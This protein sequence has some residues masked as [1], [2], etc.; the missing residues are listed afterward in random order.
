MKFE[1]Y[2]KEFNKNDNEYIKTDISNT[3]CTDWLKEEIPV[4]ECSDKVIEK[5]YY[6][7]WWTYRKHIKNT[8]EGYVITEFLPKVSWSGIYNVINAPV[9]H[10]LMEGRWLKNAEKYIT[11]YINIFFNYPEVGLRYSNWLIWAIN[12]FGEVKN[13]IDKK[14][15]LKKSVPY[16]KMWEETHKTE[17]EL[18][19]SVDGRDA[20]EFSISGSPHKKAIPGLRPTLNSYMYGEAK[21]IYL[22]SKECGTPKE[23]Y[24]EKSEKIKNA[25]QMLLWRE[26]F[27]K[28]VHPENGKFNEISS[29]DTANVPRELIGYI[30]WYFSIPDSGD[31]LFELLE[32]KDVFLAEQGLTTAEKSAKDFLYEADHECL[33][34]GYVWPFAT[35]QTLTALI[36]TMMKSE[37]NRTK[38]SDMFYRLLSL[39][40][41]QH[42][43]INEYGKEVMWIDEVMSPFKHIWTSREKLKQWGWK[44]EK[45]GFE[46]GKDYNHSTFCDLVISALTGFN[47]KNG[48]VKFDPII[49]STWEYFSIDNLYIRGSRY[50]I[51]YDKTRKY[52]GI[53]GIRIY[54]DGKEYDVRP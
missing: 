42:T 19:W 20:M 26:G 13:C 53:T 12:K 39:Y 38:Y 1:E 49:P 36:N 4:L 27:F 32:D 7:R 52:Y 21:T 10:H 8:P 3:N 33:W 9:G 14:D 35:A 43:R 45:G 51:E 24:L 50:R 11:D 15:I 22:L 47:L 25:M 40:A 48:T 31:E 30:P 6:F 17:T 34:N 46:R 41:M 54:K 18:F 37:G 23:E 28:A 29:I 16:Y 5:T 44:T 2:I